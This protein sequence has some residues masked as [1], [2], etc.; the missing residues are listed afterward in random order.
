LVIIAAGENAVTHY[1]VDHSRRLVDNPIPGKK[2]HGRRKFGCRL[3]K[4]IA[5][6]MK[7]IVPIT[8]Q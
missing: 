8:N 2:S 5:V 1:P 4:L 7:M 6:L 3:A